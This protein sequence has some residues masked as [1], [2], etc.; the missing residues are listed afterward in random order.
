MSE[1]DVNLEEKETP[2]WIKDLRNA[3]G[4]E[5]ENNMS[6][7]KKRKLLS[8][9]DEED[10]ENLKSDLEKSIIED[11]GENEEGN[12]EIY[13]TDSNEDLLSNSYSTPTGSPRISETGGMP[14]STS[15]IFNKKAS[16]KKT[17]IMDYIFTKKKNEVNKIINK[18][19]NFFSKSKLEIKKELKKYQEKLLTFIQE[20]YTVIE[21]L[22][23][24]EIFLRKS[25]KDELKTLK[26]FN[27]EKAIYE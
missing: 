3:W 7:E 22:E 10:E 13:F 6:D 4:E 8:F 5:I 11:E 23:T 2:S 15:Q 9:P 27:M 25:S 19:G 26:N 17:S 20:S 18:L 1:N 12:N 24:K 16:K 14:R 21:K